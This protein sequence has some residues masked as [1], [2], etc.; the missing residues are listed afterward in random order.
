MQ[1][2]KLPCY[3][4]E[5]RV[6]GAGGM[7][8]SDIHEP[9]DYASDDPEDILWNEGYNHRADGI[10]S[11]ILACA[12]EGIDVSTPEWIRAIETTVDALSQHGELGMDDGS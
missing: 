7:I 11:L 5:L 4:I 12:C 9:I 3:G 6:E 2:T 8:S 10:T 1:V